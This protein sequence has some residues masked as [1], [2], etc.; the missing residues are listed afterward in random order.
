MAVPVPLREYFLIGDLHTSAL[1]SSGGSIDWLCLPAFDA[2]SVFGALID[3][4]RGGSF[5]VRAEGA[6]SRSA[7]LPESA[8]VE[9]VFEEKQAAFSVR[10][11]ML[12]LPK[13]A[14][15]TNVLVRKLSGLH[16]ISTVRFLCSPRPDYARQH[17]VFHKKSERLLQAPIGEHSLWIHLPKGASVRLENDAESVEITITVADG[18]SAELIMEYAATPSSS[19]RDRDCEGETMTFWR[20]WI[21]RGK[22]SEEERETLIRSAITLKLLQFAPTG[23]F[24]AAPTTSLPEEIGGVRNWDYRYTWVR[25]GAFTADALAKLG[26][27]EEAVQFLRFFENCVPDVWVRRDLQVMYT[28]HGGL[29]R[30]EEELVHLCGYADSSPVR[31]GNGA[32][33]QR[34]LDIYGSLLDLYAECHRQGMTVTSHGRELILLCARRIAELWEERE[35]GIWEVR[36]GAFPFTYGKVMCWVGMDRALRMANTLGVSE[37]QKRKWKALREE[38]RAWIWDKCFDA[39]RGTFR[40]HPETAAQDAT[41][42]FFVLLGFLEPS[43]PRTATVIEETRKELSASDIF[44][45]RYKAEDGLSGGEGAFLLCSFWMIAALAKS[46]RMEEARELLRKAESMLPPSG[47]MAEEIDPVTGMYL[48]NF[49]QA[50]SHLGYITAA[51]SVRC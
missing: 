30:G 45:Y 23:A 38:I 32:A 40:Q 50:F 33:S 9:T 31:I 19:F 48:G 17:I 29:L 6:V 26:Y 41:N 46:G 16:G 18:D 47:L 20:E 28:V 49:P 14:T 27:M 10:D 7:Y 13:R 21:A 36:G 22:F 8:I 44:V 3:E 15:A 5:R 35:S 24:V 34:Q 39:E 51:M 42:F 1:V 12:P 4:E 43:D 37:E 2:P 25:D 11:F